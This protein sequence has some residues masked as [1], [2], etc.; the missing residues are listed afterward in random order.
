MP[1]FWRPILISSFLLCAFAPAFSQDSTIAAT[2]SIGL[3]TGYA[4]A[5]FKSEKF[6]ALMQTG[7][8]LPLQ[9]Y[10]RR[11]T[12]RMQL[13]AQAYY[14]SL[15]LASSYATLVTHER[16]GQLQFASHFLVGNRPKKITTWVGCVL[17][18][19]GAD[20]DFSSKFGNGTSGNNSSSEGF[21]SL[22]PSVLFEN[23]IGANNI[24]LQIWASILAYAI[25]PID[26]TDAIEGKFV[27]LHTF[28]KTEARLSYSKFFS[29]RWEGRIDGQ[30]QFYALSIDQTVYKINSQVV[31]SIAYKL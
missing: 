7:S 21:L 1:R 20:R 25:H 6:S 29:E 22:N 4:Y 2:N 26:G 31:A 24:S 12:P 30:F 27:S 8:G 18:A 17:D 19:Q 13:H 3:G 10:F 16:N 9:V 5:G 11:S 23:K 14:T 28:S 15:S